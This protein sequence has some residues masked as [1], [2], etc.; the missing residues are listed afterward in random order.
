MSPATTN[1]M[2]QF[3]SWHGGLVLFAAAFIEQSGLPIPAAPF[4]LAAGALAAAGQVSLIAA[5]AWTAFACLAADTFWFYAGHCG[6]GRLLPFFAHLQR[7]RR[8]RRS[9]TGARATLRGL[10]ILTAAKFLPLGTLVPL[11]AGTLDV[12]PLRFVLLDL[13]GSLIYASVYLLL[14]FFFHHQ[15]RQLTD[16][17][18]RL[19]T[20]GLVLLLASAAIYGGF[21]FFRHYRSKFQTG[22]KDAS[23][24]SQA[25]LSQ[26][27]LKRKP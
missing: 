4:L 27:D 16:I 13:P 18:R 17:V 12:S 14:G 11:R 1:Q 25:A 8:P 6:K 10:R 20:A 5:I 21:A 3:L 22:A 19:G 7:G 9:T 2:I 26:M 24:N 15:L 23:R